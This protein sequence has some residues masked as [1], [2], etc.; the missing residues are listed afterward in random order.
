M[1]ADSL[2]TWFE[3]IAC[4]VARENF[5]LELIVDDQDYILSALNRG[6]AM[7]RVSA[8]SIALKG[9]VAAP[10]QHSLGARTDGRGSI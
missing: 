8:A 5:A 7:G 10:I 1:N 2:A 4:A 6:E 3:P 9:F